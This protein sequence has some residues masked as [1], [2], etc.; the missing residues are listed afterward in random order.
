MKNFSLTTL[1]A[2]WGAI[3]SSI[4]FGWTLY[5]DLR[6]RARIKLTAEVRRIAQ[7]TDGKYFTI[8]PDLEIDGASEA[9]FVVISVV[10][11]GRRRMHWKGAG[12][13]YKHPVNGKNGFVLSPRYLPR[14]LEEQDS[15]DEFTELDSEF[16]R[17][18]IK[19]LH[20]WDV[21]GRQWSV[22]RRDLKRLVADARKY[23]QSE[24]PK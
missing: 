8:A 22:S 18:N 13:Y 16:I 24:Y 7:R 17:G 21:A 23:S 5:R 15:H 6:D 11:V 10:N 19:R 4:V 9:L 3:L 2:V 14:V 1:L 20:V 12:G